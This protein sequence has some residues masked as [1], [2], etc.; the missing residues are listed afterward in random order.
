MRCLH[1]CHS[2]DDAAKM[3]VICCV[4]FNQR[5]FECCWQALASHF[6]V[7]VGAFIVLFSCCPLRSHPPQQP[8]ICYESFNSGTLVKKCCFT[9]HMFFFSFFFSILAFQFI[10]VVSL[11]SQRR[12]GRNALSHCL[13]VWCVIMSVEDVAVKNLRDQSLTGVICIQDSLY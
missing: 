10:S 7:T 4:V 1:M 13:G 2:G 8:Y 3:D 5:R 12:V 6:K 9:R 11:T